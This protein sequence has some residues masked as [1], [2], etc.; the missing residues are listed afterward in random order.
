MPFHGEPITPKKIVYEKIGIEKIL[1]MG[2]RKSNINFLDFEIYE[3][4][5]SLI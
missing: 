3:R 5:S 1:E 2:F 4:D